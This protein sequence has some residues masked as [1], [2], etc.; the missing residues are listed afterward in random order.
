VSL[1]LLHIFEPTSIC[2]SSFISAHVAQGATISI[3]WTLAA[4]SAP[5]VK[6]ARTSH[7]GRSR[8][9]RQSLN[10]INGMQECV[11]RSESLSSFFLTTEHGR[12]SQ[13]C[14]VVRGLVILSLQSS[15]L[16][17]AGILVGANLFEHLHHCE[18]SL[19]HGKG[20]PGFG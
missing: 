19:C 9:K 15:W 4:R 20:D 14:V 2:R 10:W 16:A 18:W 11:H 1:C 12:E 8:V 5:I 13:A 7:V 6:I 17:D 3:R